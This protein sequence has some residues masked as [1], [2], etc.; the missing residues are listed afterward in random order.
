MLFR[1]GKVSRTA[2]EGISGCTKV[3][4]IFELALLLCYPHVWRNFG[5]AVTMGIVL[6]ALPLIKIATADLLPYYEEWCHS[7]AVHRCV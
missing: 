1:S 5:Y 3:Y 7:L 2:W 4:G 6:L